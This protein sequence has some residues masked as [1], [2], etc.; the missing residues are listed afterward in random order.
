MAIPSS[1]EVMSK[2]IE[3]WWLGLSR[4]NASML[5]TNAANDVFMS[6]APRAYSMPSTMVGS[7]GGVC[8]FSMGPDG[9]TSVWPANT[10][11]G[12]AVPLRA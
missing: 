1:S 7:N 6:A 10:N 5:V 9:T 4:T 2:P 3:P 12:L 8:H 11:S